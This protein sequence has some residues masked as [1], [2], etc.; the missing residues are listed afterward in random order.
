MTGVAVKVTL[1]PE[2]IVAP[3]FATILTDGTTAVVTVIVISFDV[4]VIG[5]AQAND[6]VTTQ[7]TLAPL[8]NAAF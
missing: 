1:V 6:E 2:Q 7:V 3:G 8:A 5:F 4:A